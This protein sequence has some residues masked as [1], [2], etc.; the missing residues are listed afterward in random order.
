MSIQGNA[1]TL[2]EYK[3]FAI[4][5]CKFNIFFIILRNKYWRVRIRMRNTKFIMNFVLL[6]MVQISR[7]ITWKNEES[8]TR[9]ELQDNISNF[10]FMIDTLISNSSL[11]E[12]IYATSAGDES[13]V[14]RILHI[15]WV[16]IASWNEEQERNGSF[17][18]HGPSVTI[19]KR[20]WLHETQ[21][22]I[23]QIYCSNS[24]SYDICMQ[25]ISCVCISSVTWRYPICL[26]KQNL[27]LWWRVNVLLNVYLNHVYC[28]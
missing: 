7:Q 10:K 24:T 17:E 8:E 14:I 23:K 28:Y 21:Q 26:K 16:S 25:L 15:N 20:T 6:K 19:T 1:I 18:G 13:I 3:L 12:L 22:F 5:T 27:N 4:F 11:I 2:C 9:R